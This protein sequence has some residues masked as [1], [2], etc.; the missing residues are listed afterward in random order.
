[1]INT[2]CTICGNQRSDQDRLVYSFDDAEHKMIS[3]IECAHCCNIYS[4]FET[5]IDVDKYY[6]DKDYSIQNTEK[7]VFYRIQ[8]KEYSAVLKKAKNFLKSSHPAL[9]DFGSGKGLLLSFAK[10]LGFEVKGVE[11]SG[12]R[13]TYSKE[14]FKVEVS[15]SVYTDGK[16]F[17]TDF[18]VLTCMHVLEHLPQPS[19]LLERLIEHNLKPKGLLIVEVPNY[20]SWQS[21]WAGKN[22]LHLDVPRHVT[23]FSALQIKNIINKTNCR[24]IAVEYFSWHLGIIG[25][26]QT[27]LSLFGYTGFLM[28][29]LK[30]ERTVSLL[31]KV[32]CVLPFAILLEWVAAIFKKGGIIRCYAI[33]NS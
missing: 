32:A 33:K 18:D 1:M 17:P 19:S 21:K 10:E 14:R 12:P 9:L 26:A 13:A 7:T 3:I 11:T 31:L 6:D 8:K 25:M 23:H 30:H 5:E 27:L 22:W 24:I 20:D 4:F 2:Q 28:G 15:S 29:E 16:I